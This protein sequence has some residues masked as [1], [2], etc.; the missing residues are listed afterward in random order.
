M[1]P[2]QHLPLQE[3]NLSVEAEAEVG[4]EPLDFVM[5]HQLHHHQ[6]AQRAELKQQEETRQGQLFRQQQLQIEGAKLDQLV[7]G[8]SAHLSDLC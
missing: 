8:M 6:Q 7:T 4:P 3:Q 1:S 2:L 5:L